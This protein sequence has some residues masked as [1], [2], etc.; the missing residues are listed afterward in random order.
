MHSQP[1]PTNGDAGVSAVTVF[2][3]CTN[4][5]CHAGTSRCIQP[6]NAVG[7]IEGLANKASWSGTKTLAS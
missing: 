4:K 2:V 5:H 3:V 7:S 1:P 6:S